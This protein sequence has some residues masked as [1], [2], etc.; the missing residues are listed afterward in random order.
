M[1]NM[2]ESPRYRGLLR[3]I[4]IALSLVLAISNTSVAFSNQT[5]AKLEISQSNKQISGTVVD[6]TENH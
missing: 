6:H 1:N 4:P 2:Y 3:S 5:T